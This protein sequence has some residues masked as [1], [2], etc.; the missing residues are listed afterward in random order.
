MPTYTCWSK[1]NTITAENRQRIATALTDLHHEVTGAPRYLVQVLFPEVDDTAV[2]LAGRPVSHGHV[3]IRA[4]IRSG[5][6]TG[7]KEELLLRMVREVAD[8]LGL[9]PD[10][11]WAYLCDIPGHAM[12]EYGALLPEPGGEDGW[13]SVL[14]ERVRKRVEGLG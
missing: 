6:T 13:L 10:D 11:V 12:T 3:W 4:D 2:F 14:P 7:Q 5:R 1:R 8:I 9:Q